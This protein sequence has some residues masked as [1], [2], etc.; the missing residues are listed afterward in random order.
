[1]FVFTSFWTELYVYAFYQKNLISIE[2]TQ[3]VTNNYHLKF[4][5]L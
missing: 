2:Y 1:M 4:I 5:C 3:N